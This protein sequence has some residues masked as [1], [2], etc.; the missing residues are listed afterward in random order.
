MNGGQNMGDKLGQESLETKI[1][2]E[3]DDEVQKVLADNCLRVEDILSQEGINAKVIFG[4]SPY[5]DEARSK[6]VVQIILASSFLVAA[7]G[8]AISKVLNALSIRPH[9]VKYYENEEL[10][11]ASGNIILNCDGNPIYKRNLR[12]ELHQ[13]NMNQIDQYQANLDLKNGLGMRFS[14]EMKQG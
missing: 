1:Y 3:F 14:S 8:Y 13:P 9:L 12:Y 5:E 7:I 6:D 2:L 4:A 10:R 11:D